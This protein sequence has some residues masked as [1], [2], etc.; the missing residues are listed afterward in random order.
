MSR[1]CPAT[2]RLPEGDFV[3][4]LQ[5]FGLPPPCYPISPA[6]HTSLYWTHF[7]MVLLPAC[8]P[9]ICLQPTLV[10][11][12]L[13]Q[14]PFGETFNRPPRAIATPIG[15]EVRTSAD[16]LRTKWNDEF[17]CDG[18]V[19]TRA[20]RDRAQPRGQLQLPPGRRARYRGICWTWASPAPCRSPRTIFASCRASRRYGSRSRATSRRDARSSLQRARR[21]GAQ[22]S[23]RE[24]YARRGSPT[25]DGHSVSPDRRC[26]FRN[27]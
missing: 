3:D 21:I 17:L 22:P 23:C 25:V 10:L 4:R 24:A 18:G 5:D 12:H 13:S 6:E 8:I 9:G 15:H 20:D 19:P 7:R 27:R 26:R 2:R 14:Y 16:A 1:G 11:L